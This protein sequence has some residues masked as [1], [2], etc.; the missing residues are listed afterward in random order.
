MKASIATGLICFALGWILCRQW[1]SPP[2]GPSRDSIRIDNLQQQLGAAEARGDSVNAVNQVLKTR[3]AARGDS[4]V[5]AIQDRPR[6][7]PPPPDTSAIAVEY[8]KART[9][10]AEALLDLSNAAHKIVE[11]SLA[12]GWQSQIV[13]TGRL[14]SLVGQV[15]DSL[16]DLKI[17][18]GLKDQALAKA[19]RA[20]EIGTAN[21][22][23]TTAGRPALT[24][25]VSCRPLKLA[26]K[27]L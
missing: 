2:A 24:F 19:D 11:D 10:C 15:R 16:E 25:G 27:V 18:V 7:A 6:P 14:T 22:G 26:K 20:C 23:V 5:K 21:F 13:E 1:P 4:I 12:N 17:E 3:L 9:R 8:W